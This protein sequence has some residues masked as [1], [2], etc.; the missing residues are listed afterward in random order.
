MRQTTDRRADLFHVRG[1]KGL[2]RLPSAKQSV[3]D[4]FSPHR[5]EEKMEQAPI[6]FRG[7]RHETQSVFF[8]VTDCNRN[9]SFMIS[10][11]KAAPIL[12][13]RVVNKNNP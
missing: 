11:C 2:D 4:D 9:S 3:A 5:R 1:E 8:A 10:I 13:M 6:M 7:D 12:L